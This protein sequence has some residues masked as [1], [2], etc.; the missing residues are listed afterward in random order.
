M[1]SPRYGAREVALVRTCHRMRFRRRMG[2]SLSGQMVS[3]QARLWGLGKFP[4]HSRA[5]QTSPSGQRT[6]SPL[7]GLSR[8]RIV[9]VS[10]PRIATSCRH[11]Q[12]LW[13]CSFVS[14]RLGCP[15][16]YKYSAVRLIQL[17]QPGRWGGV[18]CRENIGK[19]ALLVSKCSPSVTIRLAPL[20]VPMVASTV[21]CV[22]FLVLY[23]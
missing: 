3:S 5:C 9:V 10:P 7:M 6:C 19:G 20:F 1:L 21:C 11:R 4:Q 8:S 13:A 22:W 15:V 14:Y 12:S 16:V 18:S 23:Y 2:L 17:A